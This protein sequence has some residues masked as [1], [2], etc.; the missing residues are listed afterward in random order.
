MKQT[1]FIIYSMYILNETTTIVV[2]YL[3][4]NTASLEN[5]SPFVA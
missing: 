2:S 4:E 5:I 1:V 3:S